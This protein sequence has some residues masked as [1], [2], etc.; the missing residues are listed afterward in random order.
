MLFSNSECSGKHCLA[1]P[2]PSELSPAIKDSFIHPS[3]DVCLPSFA[4]IGKQL[5]RLCFGRLRLRPGRRWICP[6]DHVQ[7]D[8]LVLFSRNSRWETHR[9]SFCETLMVGDE[10][11]EKMQTG[12]STCPICIVF[13]HDLMAMGSPYQTCWRRIRFPFSLW[14]LLRHIRAAQLLDSDRN[15]LG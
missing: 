7:G 2:S 13:P 15:V 4:H 10:K 5:S 11:N 9:L 6:F 1:S 14:S 8:D 3:V 12:Y